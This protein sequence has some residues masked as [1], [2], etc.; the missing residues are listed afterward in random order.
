MKLRGVIAAVP[1]PISEDGQPLKERFLSHCRY[2]L[3]N[4]CDGLNVLGSTGEATSFSGA[5]RREVMAWAAQGLPRERLMVG[6]GSPSLAEAI[7]LTEAADDLGFPVALVLPPWY[8][9]P[10]SDD[11]LFSFYASLH[12]ALGARRIQIWFYDYPQLTG[13]RIPPQVIARLTALS[14]ERFGGLKDS[15]G[16]LEHCDAVLAAAPGIAVFPSSETALEN[17]RA[18]GFAGCISATA[19]LTS[20]L[21]QQLWQ[22]KTSVAAQ[23]TRLRQRIAAQPLIPSV[24]HLVGR[25]HGDEV[26]RRVLPPFLPLETEVAKALEE[27]TLA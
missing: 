14:P 26:W 21:C 10:L 3:E 25:L 19:N 17:G 18:R 7:A 5:A 24:K 1:T 2:L 11:G 13:I 12:K 6:T 8:Y 23:V 20:P 4:G 15:S 27:E 9:K 22:G 16:N